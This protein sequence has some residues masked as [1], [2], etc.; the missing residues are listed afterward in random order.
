LRT[1][2]GREDGH[3]L[4]AGAGD[5]LALQSPLLLFLAAQERAPLLSAA[6]RAPQ[7]SLSTLLL[8]P[9]LRFWPACPRHPS[10]RHRNYHCFASW[11][12]T[13]ADPLL[14]PSSSTWY[15][16]ALLSCAVLVPIRFRFCGLLCSRLLPA[17]HVSAVGIG[18]ARP[19]PR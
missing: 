17:R 13:P 2:Q 6:A 8:A 5:R 4:A 12:S 18:I 9:V 3:Q 15:A 10:R 1:K 19:D 7:A 16:L 14:N 11:N